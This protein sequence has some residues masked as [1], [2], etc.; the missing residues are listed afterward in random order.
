MAKRLDKLEKTQPGKKPKRKPAAKA[1][2]A[3]KAGKVPK[4]TASDQ[5]LALVSKSQKGIDINMLRKKT[6]IGENNLR[7]SLYRMKKRGM[8]KGAGKGVYVRS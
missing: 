8:I 4:A 7:V 2:P 1:K 6:G 5:I 3:K